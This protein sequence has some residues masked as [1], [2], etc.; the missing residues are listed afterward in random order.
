VP[1]FVGRGAPLQYTLLAP[2]LADSANSRRPKR[3]PAE[4]GI[5]DDRMAIGAQQLSLFA[6]PMRLI[7]QEMRVN[8]VY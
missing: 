3:S 1:I 8:A 7:A 4:A 6:A 2:N 5:V